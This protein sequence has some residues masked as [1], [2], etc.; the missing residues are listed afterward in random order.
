MALVSLP[1]DLAQLLVSKKAESSLRRCPGGPDTSLPKERMA[2]ECFPEGLPTSTECSVREGGYPQ[3]D[4][5][6]GS[7]LQSGTPSCPQAPPIQDT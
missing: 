7:W 4:K 6:M 1:R 3:G 5:N 2:L